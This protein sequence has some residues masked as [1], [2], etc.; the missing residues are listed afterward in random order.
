MSSSRR[1]FD[2]LSAFIGLCRHP[3]HTF[4]SHCLSASESEG[5]R[6]EPAIHERCRR[7]MA[8]SG[9]RERER[10]RE[11]ERKSSSSSND[12]SGSSSS[13]RQR[14]ECEVNA[15][16][17]SSFSP[18]PP[19][20]VARMQSHRHT[21]PPPS[22]PLATCHLYSIRCS[23]HF[24]EFQVPGSVQVRGVPIHA[25]VSGAISKHE[26][27]KKSKKFRTSKNVAAS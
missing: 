23:G 8:M 24:A 18:P 11:R 14:S 2:R 16:A 7:C 19:A 4:L 21:H 10:E 12:L 17:R 26:G 15:L 6:Q 13:R 1:R 27:G 22:R 20:S 5:L 9:Q 25:P 3:S